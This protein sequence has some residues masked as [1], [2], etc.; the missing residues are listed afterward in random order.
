V[1][2]PTLEQIAANPCGLR[3]QD[4]DAVLARELLEHEDR[5]DALER[6]HP[7]KGDPELDLGVTREMLNHDLTLALNRAERAERERDE[8]RRDLA[9]RMEKGQEQV[10][11]L[12]ADR[13]SWR[14]RHASAA[15]RA[16]R[17]KRE[18]DEANRRTRHWH[19][20]FAR[21]CAERDA[22]RADADRM[23]EAIGLLRQCV[24]QHRPG[25]FALTEGCTCGLQAALDST[26]GDS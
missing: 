3:S 16:E 19:E 6:S 15:N 23:R 26:R 17:A 4:C 1:S 8:A 21:T 20:A 14:E 24:L 9:W 22:A 11:R 12:M 10:A 5:L 25:C 18:R 13:D 2:E 7:A